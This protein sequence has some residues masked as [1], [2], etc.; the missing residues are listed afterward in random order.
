MSFSWMFG[1]VCAAAEMEKTDSNASN[2]AGAKMEFRFFMLRG[3]K[4]PGRQIS[5]EIRH[6]KR[7]AVCTWQTPGLKFLLL[8]N[9]AVKLHSFETSY[10]TVTRN[11][12]VLVP[13]SI[14]T[15]YTPACNAEK[16][17]STRCCPAGMLPKFCVIT[18]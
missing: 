5:C 4:F 8:G 11:V 16:L 3:F 18:C 15:R 10:L 12:E 2:E 14:D 17:S 13:A 6:K 1:T 7:P 9:E